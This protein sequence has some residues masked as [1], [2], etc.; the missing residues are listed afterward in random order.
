[1]A[2]AASA[3][4]LRAFAAKAGRD[5]L[6]NLARQLRELAADKDLLAERQLEA[7]G[8]VRGSAVDLAAAIAEE[9]YENDV[10]YAKMIEESEEPEAQILRDVVVAQRGN[11]ERLEGLR[12]ALLASRGDVPAFATEVPSHDR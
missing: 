11:A 4:K 10:L 8:Q 5:G 3:A 1:M 9:R 6:P 7:T 12:Q 2:E